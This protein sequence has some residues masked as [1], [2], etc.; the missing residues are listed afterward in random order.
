MSNIRNWTKI[1]YIERVFYKLWDGVALPRPVTQ[2]FVVWFRIGFFGGDF[3]NF[4]I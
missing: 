2:T 3:S 4:S 1:W